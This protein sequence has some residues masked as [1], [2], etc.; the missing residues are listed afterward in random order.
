MQLLREAVPRYA[1]Q[2]PTSTSRQWIVKRWSVFPNAV[3]WRRLSGGP[4][5]LRFLDGLFRIVVGLE[6]N[7]TELVVDLALLARQPDG[8]QE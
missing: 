1:R 6:L 4:G 5:E 7:A 8:I 3:A 2:W